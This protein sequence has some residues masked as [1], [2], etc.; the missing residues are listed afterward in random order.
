M[1]RLE[2]L[3]KEAEQIKNMK[4]LCFDVMDKALE[5]YRTEIDAIEVYGAPNREVNEGG[6]IKWNCGEN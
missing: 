5:W 6:P 3:K 4:C 2:L 1:T